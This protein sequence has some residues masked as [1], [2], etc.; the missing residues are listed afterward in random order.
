MSTRVTRAE[1]GAALA[2]GS[3]N[4]IQR[5]PLGVVIHWEGPKMG[6]YPHSKCAG[7]VRGIQR[8]HQGA[9]KWS[10][11][12]YNEVVCPHG[13]RF[14]GR[15]YGV[16][17]AANGTN[18]ANRE[19]Y[20]ICVMVGKGDPVTQECLQA[21]ADAVADYRAHGHAGEDIL[22]HRD[23]VAT[24]C[25]GDFLYGHVKRG[26][27]GKG[28]VPAAPKAPAKSAP[29]SAVPKALERVPGPHYPFPLPG[30]YYFGKDDGSNASV[31]GWYGRK[32]KGKTD[33]QWLQEFGKQ[34]ARRG[35]NVGKGKTWLSGSGNDGKFGAEYD[36]LVRRFQKD[37]GLKQDGKIGPRTWAAAFLEP[38]D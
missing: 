35:W 24:D 26:T 5:N 21:V 31:S 25:P 20:A 22:G 7:K 19:R 14:E 12:A 8:F 37:Q 17:S 36:A 6:S 38:I 27:F 10:D 3:L 15:G 23:C 1:W 9:R 32:F 30:G 11:I 34:L 28:T 16:G 33:R 4:L 29:K 2:T 13:V 18:E